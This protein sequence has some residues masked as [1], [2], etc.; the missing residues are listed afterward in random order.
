MD[1]AD[2]Q[3][4]LSL[5]QKLRELDQQRVATL[6]N[7]AVIIEQNETLQKQLDHRTKGENLQHQLVIQEKDAYISELEETIKEN[8]MIIKEQQDYIEEGQTEKLVQLQLDQ[9]LKEREQLQKKVA[10]MQAMIDQKD[11]KLKVLQDLMEPL[12]SKI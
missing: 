8:C 10:E 2:K 1:S 12:E 5:Q 6:E 9:S 7:M 4:I 11:Q 3:L